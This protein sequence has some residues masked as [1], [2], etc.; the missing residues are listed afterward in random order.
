MTDVKRMGESHRY[1][2]A[3]RRGDH[4]YLG[5][6]CAYNSF[7]EDIRTQ[8]RE[9]MERIDT[10]LSGADMKRSDVMMVN[11]YLSDA[12]DYAGFNEIWDAWI[13]R[14]ALPTRACTGANLI[15]PGCKLEVSVYAFAG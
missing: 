7:G 10:F 3:I 6:Q 1:C 5:G 14:D 2:Q 4:L 9:V 13:D 12:D 11:V 15:L 8:A